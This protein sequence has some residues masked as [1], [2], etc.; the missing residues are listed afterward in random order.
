MIFSGLRIRRLGF[1]SLRVRYVMS[2]G[3]R[4][5]LNPQLGFL[6]RVRLSEIQRHCG[7]EGGLSVW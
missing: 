7:R 4:D 2:Q 1:E 6:I 3:I 5:T